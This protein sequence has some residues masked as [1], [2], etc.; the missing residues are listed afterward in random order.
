[1]REGEIEIEKGREDCFYFS[2]EGSRASPGTHT[3]A[4][5]LT[6][7]PSH[8]HQPTHSPRAHT[9]VVMHGPFFFLLHK[10]FITENLKKNP[11]K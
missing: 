6:H 7:S 4:H 8:T 1:V 3:H 9:Q 5:S 11:E 10:H 2:V